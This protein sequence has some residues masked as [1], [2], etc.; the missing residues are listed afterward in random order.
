MHA[1]AEIKC[2][3][4]NLAIKSGQPLKRWIKGVSVMLE[5]VAGNINVQKLRAILLLEADFN[6]LHKIVFN[7]RLIPKLE[8]ADAIPVKIIGGRRAQAATHLSL[9]KK[10]IA[11]I[12]NVRKVPT[13]TVCAD[14]TNCYDRVAHPFASLC[15][16]CFGLEI[17]H[18]VVLFR[19][20]QSMK[21][22]LRTSYGL[23]QNAYAG[24]HGK[25]FQG[26]AQ[27][28]GAAPAL[29]MI[30]SIFLVKYL[31]NKKVTTQLSAPVSRI[32]M[33]LAALMFADDT[34]LYV[35]NSGIDTT[36]EIVVKAQKLLD[37]WYNILT[38]TG[39]NLKLSKCYW[40]LQDYQWHQGECEMTHPASHKLHIDL[41]NHRKEVMHLRA[42]QMR[43]LVGVPMQ[44]NHQNDQIITSILD[45]TKVHQIKLINCKLTLSDIMF[46][47]QYYW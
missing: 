22:F 17:S 24:E 37:V 18:L 11:D 32:V 43:T 5:K 4:V 7:N 10:L 23:S 46:G 33:P 26:I 42:D 21:M 47:Y 20:T 45:K 30:I 16:Q 28:S 38:I 27:G 1:I 9:S 3:L 31:Y 15:A 34:D 36:K 13:I 29:W 41:N 25:P 2:K 8:E 39:G 40:T 12:A 19:A 35:F 44:L 14:A 6:A